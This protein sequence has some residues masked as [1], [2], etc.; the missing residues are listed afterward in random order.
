MFSNRPL[1]LKVGASA[2]GGL[3]TNWTVG[4]AENK[5]GQF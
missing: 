3:A 1:I 5:L 4:G 2:S